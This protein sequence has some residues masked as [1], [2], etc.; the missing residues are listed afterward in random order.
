MCN[1]VLDFRFLDILDLNRILQGLHQNCRISLVYRMNGIRD[2]VVDR[3]VQLCLINHDIGT[4]RKLL[5]IFV[6]RIVGVEIYA[7]LL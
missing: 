5:Y 6:N 2:I 3:V 4:C 1:A 7:F